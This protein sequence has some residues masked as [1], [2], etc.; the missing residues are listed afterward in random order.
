MAKII[1]VVCARKDKYVRFSVYLLQVGR[2]VA[3]CASNDCRL[4]ESGD[5]FNVCR[6]ERRIGKR[7]YWFICDKNILFHRGFKICNRAEKPLQTWTNVS[8]GRQVSP[9]HQ[10]KLLMS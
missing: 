3:T 5:M 8:G 2:C 7:E 9:S 6:A 1:C 10:K 4:L